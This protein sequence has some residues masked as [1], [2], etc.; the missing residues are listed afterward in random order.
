VLEGSYQRGWFYSTASSTVEKEQ[1]IFKLSHEIN[2]GFIPLI[3]TSIHTI[4]KHHGQV[5]L[6]IFTKVKIN[7]DNVS[8]VTVPTLKISGYKLHGLKGRVFA[9]L[10]FT[11]IITEF[12]SSQL[13]YNQT[14][15]KDIALQLNVN[16]RIA[17]INLNIATISMPKLQLKNVKL[18]GKNPIKNDNL[19]FIM[20]VRKVGI[21]GPSHSD[22][23]L[24]NVH[25]PSLLKIITSQKTMF[26]LISQGL[27]LL[28]YSPKISI[29]NL[30]LNTP[31]GLVHGNLQIEVKPIENLLLVLFNP[32]PLLNILDLQLA[33]NIPKLFISKTP[34]KSLQQQLKIL[35]K[36][37]VLI[38]NLDYYQSYINLNKGLLQ[39]NGKQLSLTE[40]LQ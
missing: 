33:V 36:R 27:K 40:I 6:N 14:K 12:K 21:Y 11:N 35:I 2:H 20:E 22:I 1:Q 8:D 37:G 38:E 30:I 34:Y 18:T 4:I 19:K 31:E 7:G 28:E 32:N 24:S 29:T 9:D 26:N 25:L 3:K 5:L 16:N 13:N 39:V 15:A 23:E 17:E 10:R